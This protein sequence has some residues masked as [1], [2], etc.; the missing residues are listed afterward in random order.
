MSIL[1]PA[2]TEVVAAQPGRTRRD[3]LVKT[4]GV[5]L[6]AG[7]LFVAGEAITAQPAAA[8]WQSN[9][10]Y[11]I[12][13]K[14]LFHAASSGH[15]PEGYGHSS[16]TSANYS[17][18]YG[19]A[20]TPPGYQAGWRFCNKCR[21]MFNT[22]GQQVDECWNGEHSEAVSGQYFL[23]TYPTSGYQPGWRYCGYCACLNYGPNWEDSTCFS[24]PYPGTWKHDNDGSFE[25][26]LAYSS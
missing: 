10:R 19:L 25:Y 11:C 9:W 16:P 17:L 22:Y 23:R 1:Q 2:R 12:K 13:C 26:H 5:V 8:A 4:A 24:G 14:I 20:S 18:E 6:G 21:C 15:C 3:V 7:G